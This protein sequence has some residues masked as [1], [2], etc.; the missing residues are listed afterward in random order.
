VSMYG[1]L[2]GIE[3]PPTSLN[4]EVTPYY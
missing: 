4:L 3:A 2:V 1:T